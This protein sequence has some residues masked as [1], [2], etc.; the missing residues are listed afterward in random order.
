MCC[1]LYDVLD[2]GWCELLRGGLQ[3]RAVGTSTTTSAHQRVSARIPPPCMEARGVWWLRKTLSWK[4]SSGARAVSFILKS[5]EIHKSADLF[6]LSKIL[7]HLRFI[8]LLRVRCYDIKVCF[9]VSQGDKNLS[10]VS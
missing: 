5:G 2:R 6:I 10:F 1:V 4:T 9:N 8:V 7:L 3:R